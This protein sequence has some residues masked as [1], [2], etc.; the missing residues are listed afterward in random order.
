[1]RYHSTTGLTHDQLLELTIRV[2]Q[3]LGPSWTIGSRTD[4]G[5]F[6]QVRLVLTIL[7]Q[8]LAQT[9]AGD[10]FGA[11]QPT[12][13]RIWRRLLPVLEQVTCLHRPGELADLARGR[14]VL[15]D[16][17]LVPTRRFAPAWA[18]NY[19]GKHRR[20]GVNIQVAATE[21]GCLLAV[22]EPVPGRR[23]DRRALAEVGWEDALAGACWIADPGYQGTNAFTPGKRR[24]GQGLSDEQRENN[25][26]LSHAR[27]GIERA[28]SHLKNWKMLATGYRGRLRELP[29]VIRVVSAIEL[30]RLGW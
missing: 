19:S 20:H 27:S 21:T 12:V 16:G 5:L 13:S 6:Q 14:I 25:A 24:P 23:H 29:A 15:V 11:S 9:V 1:M 3:V 10:L 17:T 7:R 26:M 4:L 2:S 28:I 30:Y 8:N 22:S 18:S